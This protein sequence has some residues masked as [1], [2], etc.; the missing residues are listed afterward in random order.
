MLQILTSVQAGILIRIG[1]RFSAN[2]FWFLTPIGL[3]FDWV[4]LL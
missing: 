4:G 1:L 3:E 2:F